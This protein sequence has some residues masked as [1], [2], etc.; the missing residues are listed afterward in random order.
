MSDPVNHPRHYNAHPSGVECIAIKRECC[1]NLGDAIK[2]LWRCGQKDGAPLRQDVE[3]AIWYLRDELA[4]RVS[5][6]AALPLHSGRPE[7]RDAM[8]KVVTHGPDVLIGNFLVLL[9]GSVDPVAFLKSAVFEL[10]RALEHLPEGG[11]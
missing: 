2:Y 1:S 11:A 4:F 5:G 10:S 8:L 9:L 7:L 3:K 6:D